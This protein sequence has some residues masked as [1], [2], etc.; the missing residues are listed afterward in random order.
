MSA[1]ARDLRFGLRSLVRAP[2]FAA[3]AVLSLAL[4]MGANAAIFS[5]VDGLLL[6]PF[7]LPSPERVTLLFESDATQAGRRLGGTSEATFADWR[8]E[9][10]SFSALGAMTSTNLSLVRGGESESLYIQLITASY[11]PALGVRPALGRNFSAQEERGGEQVVLLSYALWQRLFAGDRGVVGRVVELDN[12]SCQVIGVMPADFRSPLEPVPVQL[13]APLAPSAKPDRQQRQWVVYGRLADGV[14]LERARAEIADLTARLLH[15]YPKEME[16]RQARV[17]PIQEVF[18]GGFRPALLILL[19][20]GGLL[21]LIVCSNVAHLLLGRSLARQQEIA[22]RTAV[23]ASPRQILR[24]LLTESLILAGA[25]ALAG[26]LLARLGLPLIIGMVPVRPD[27]PR[28]DRVTVDA[29]V[30]LFVFAI[31]LATTLAFGLMP[32][33]VAF[34]R[35][36]LGRGSARATV[37]RRRGLLRATLVVTEVALVLVLLI[38][39]GLMVR[40]FLNLS[41]QKVARA[42]ETVLLLRTSLRGPVYDEGPARAAFFHRALEA[43]RALPGVAT[44][45]GTDLPLL[46]AKVSG[47]HFLVEG[48]EAPPPGAEPVVQVQGISPGYFETLGT[49]LLEGRSFREDDG[50]RAMPVAMVNRRFVRT[51]LAGRAPLGQGLI[52]RESN[53]EVR[54][55]VGVVDDARLSVTPPDAVPTLYVP[56]A[57]RPPTIMTFVVRTR[58]EP[59]R[60][61]DR[62]RE[63]VVRQDP[64]MVTYGIMTLAKSRADAD[65]QSRFSLALLGVFAALAMILA[66]TGIYAVISSG[67]AERTKELGIRAAF[68]ARPGDLLYL[69][70]RNGLRQAFLGLVVGLIASF[71][72]TRLLKSQLYGIAETDPV[73]YAVLS[74]AVAMVVLAACLVP[75]WRASRLDPIEALRR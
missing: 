19:G 53:G 33:R 42:P 36:A 20:A 4:G 73:T 1:L 24:Q 39:T 52:M 72:F 5:V 9:A 23:G 51:F 67:V 8:R 37:D 14:T 43:I 61:S 13:W 50:A 68:G 62:V 38:G 46:N 10:R 18:V 64:L 3:A 26:L 35:S 66:V 7:P 16:G 32:A 74:A 44:A 22:I 21:L 71:L 75:A 70:L 28:L 30:L 11:F 12:K 54:R 17:I 41:A 59:L 27:L 56:A 47:E 6:K 2:G 69:V 65:W 29:R 40:T 49:K 55:V 34:S 63:V 48:T 57:Q 60:F 25:G 15:H 31:A 58:T 45:G